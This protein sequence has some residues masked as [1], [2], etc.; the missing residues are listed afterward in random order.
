MAEGTPSKSTISVVLPSYNDRGIVRPYYDAITELLAG[1]DD[2]DY[3]LVYVDDG[4]TDGSQET[5][6]QL[7]AADPHV[8][9]V[10]LMRNYGQQRALFAGLAQSK[11]DYVVTLDGDYQYEPDVILQLVNAMGS[12]YDMAS[13]IRRKRRDRWTDVVASRVGNRIISDILNVRLADF[14]SVK[15][16]SRRLVERVLEMRHFFSDVYPSACSLRP[17]TVEIEVEHRE[18]LMGKS[19]WN[20][21][22]RLRLYVD[23]YVAYKDDQFQSP[24]RAGAVVSV[25]GLIGTVLLLGYKAVFGHSMSVTEIG[26]AGFVTVVLGFV[27]MAWSLTM[28]FLARIYK[29]NVFRE[30]YMVRAV[31]RAPDGEPTRR[32]LSPASE[33]T[34][35]D[36]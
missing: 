15:A 25:L 11:G 22:M 36:D 3:E 27:V 6:R 16:F 26:F 33:E 19:H 8:T 2:Y 30:P 32:A 18:R 9:F 28:T 13:G 31:Y 5:L 10:E 7:A 29:Q 20:I 4:S 14:G 1:Q 17:S 23:L 21:W 35:V 12:D 34:P 24:F